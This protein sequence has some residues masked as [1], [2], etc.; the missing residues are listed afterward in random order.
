[1]CKHCYNAVHKQKNDGSYGIVCKNDIDGTGVSAFFSCI[2]FVD[3]CQKC[4]H[5][6]VLTYETPCFLCSSLYLK[7]YYV[8][9]V[10][11]NGQ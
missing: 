3:K 1:M 8:E 2:E 6:N 11:E 10:A 7:P 9:E 4:I 5:R